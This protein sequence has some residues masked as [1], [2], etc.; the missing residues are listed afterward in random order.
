MATAWTETEL[1]ERALGRE[2]GAWTELVRR[3]RRVMVR[4][5]GGVLRRSR[6]SATADADEVF[7]EL[8][9]SLWRDDMR[10]LRLHD[11]RRGARL[12]TWLGLLARNAAHDFL[13]ANSAKRRLLDPVD[14]V[15]ALRCTRE[16]PLEAI[17]REENRARV[18]RLLNNVSRRDRELFALII[19]RGQSVEEVAEAMGI[20]RKTVY[21]K[22]HKLLHRLAVRADAPRAAA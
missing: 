3:Y 19:L 9:L 17:M 2:S 11:A 5:I 20:S 7:A 8:M 6:L 4:C 22:K 14:D 18:E 21:T 13:R 12:G 10:K 1:M 16:D 15:G